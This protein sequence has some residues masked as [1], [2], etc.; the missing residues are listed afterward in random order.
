MLI[1]SKELE[2]IDEKSV[3]VYIAE[4]KPVKYNN[5]TITEG[6]V[7]YADWDLD[8]WAKRGYK[9]FNVGIYSINLRESPG[10]IALDKIS[11]NEAIDMKPIDMDTFMTSGHDQ[12]IHFKVRWIPESGEYAPFYRLVE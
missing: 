7:V 8:S 2:E 11:E 3:A 9:N 4:R 1:E 10:K 5:P 12:G 6:A